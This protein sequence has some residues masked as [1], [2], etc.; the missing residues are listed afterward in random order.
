MDRPH[1][2]QFPR[3]GRLRFIVIGWG[4]ISTHTGDL[5]DE[6]NFR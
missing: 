5:F 2:A 1:P 4:I 3:T 6:P